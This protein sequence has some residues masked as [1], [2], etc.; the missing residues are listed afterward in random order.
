MR[1]RHEQGERGGEFILEVEGERIGELTYGLSGAI[2]TVRHTGVNPA[3]E[4]HGYGK[5]LVSE[6]VAFARDNK[7]K[8]QSTC[9]FATKLLDRVPA[10]ADV[11]A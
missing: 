6:A 11:R 2:M 7:L 10:F 9:W 8:M 5:R 3:H 1:I 4:G